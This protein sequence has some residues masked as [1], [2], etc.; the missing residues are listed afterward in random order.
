MQLGPELAQ[1]SGVVKPPKPAEGWSWVV[2][3]VGGAAKELNR[4]QLK[5]Q[6]EIQWMDEQQDANLMAWHQQHHLQ[7]AKPVKDPARGPSPQVPYV[8]EPGGTFRSLN[9]EEALV[10]GDTRPKPRKRWFASKR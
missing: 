2:H 5:E 3:P 7:N 8:A 6:A 1:H 10:V 4:K 9:E